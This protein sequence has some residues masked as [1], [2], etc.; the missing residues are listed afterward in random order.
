MHLPLTTYH[1]RSSLSC[2]PIHTGMTRLFNRSHT[3]APVNPRRFSRVFIVNPRRAEH[4]RQLIA[5]R[6][7]RRYLPLTQPTQTLST[8]AYN[9][10]KQQATISL[11]TAT[12][13]IYAA[14]DEATRNGHANTTSFIPTVVESFAVNACIT[15][16][17]RI[18][19]NTLVLLGRELIHV[20]NGNE[21]HNETVS[22]YYDV[23]VDLISFYAYQREEE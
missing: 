17:T 22:A 15:H 2:P 11:S 6:A 3:L 8:R 4:A 9:D 23:L 14:I 21:P 1:L 19:N 7:E 10:A 16:G 20:A 12:D 5:N 18:G 13:R